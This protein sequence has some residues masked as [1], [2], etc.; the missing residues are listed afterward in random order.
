MIRLTCL[1]FIFT[2]CLYAETTGNLLPQ[3]FFN[4]NQEHNGWNCTD[5]SH[6][7]GNNIFAGVHGDFLENTINLSDTLTQQQINDGWTSTLGADMWHWN[8][9]DTVTRMSQIITTSDGEVITQTRDI[10]LK[11]C[12]SWNCGG[13]ATYTDSYTQGINNQSDFS[14]KARFDFTESS[15]STSHRAIDLRN[16]T[17]VIEHSLIS[18]SDVQNI[19]NVTENIQE[20]I[21]QLSEDQIIAEILEIDTPVLDNI[22]FNE[23]EVI[24]DDIIEEIYL[25]QNTDDI[26]TGIIEI[27][28]IAEY[29]NQTTVEEVATEIEN[30]EEIIET[31]EVGVEAEDITETITEEIVRESEPIEEESTIELAE[32]DTEQISSRDNEV[33][34]REDTELENVEREESEPSDERRTESNDDQDSDQQENTRTEDGNNDST[35]TPTASNESENNIEQITVDRISQKVSKV[36][37][38]VDKQL[39]VTNIIVAKAMKSNLDIDSYKSINNNL[40]INQPIIDGGEYFDLREFTDNRVIYQQSKIPYNEL[41]KEYQDKVEKAEQQRIL[42]EEHLR[43]IRGY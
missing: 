23:E 4:N 8:D 43:R 3:Q 13:Y 17:L 15:Q 38:E 33:E 5:P 28:E 12:G 32:T 10:E 35:E 11:G 14:I 29:D 36:V 25:D 20:V 34:S 41:Y 2:S 7:H 6:N 42:A 26:N 19:S 22:T 9:L 21:S 18:Q 1:F 37:Q 31:A 27:F 40:F 16:P 39:V 24:I 30:F